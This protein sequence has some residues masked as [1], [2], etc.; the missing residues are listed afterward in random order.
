MA[1][2]S[3]APFPLVFGIGLGRFHKVVQLGGI[4]PTLAEMMR[5]V[6]AP[7]ILGR[8]TLGSEHL[9]NVEFATFAKEINLEHNP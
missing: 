8:A 4:V 3:P 9:I 6:H 5:V 1:K 2:D 7:R